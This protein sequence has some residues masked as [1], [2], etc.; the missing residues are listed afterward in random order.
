MKAVAFA[1]GA[2]VGAGIAV[3]MLVAA[4][5]G[6]ALGALLVKTFVE[7]GPLA[8]IAVV[9]IAGAV[10]GGIIDANS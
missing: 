5:V 8:P 3:A 7:L 1:R 10:L 6:V 2:V 9:V 4:V